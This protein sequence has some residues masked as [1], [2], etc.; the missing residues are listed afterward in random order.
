[1]T[2]TACYSEEDA[3]RSFKET[4]TGITS[5]IRALNPSVCARA[6]VR[7]RCVNTL[8]PNRHWPALRCLLVSLGP[9]LTGEKTEA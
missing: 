9:C 6:C 4:Y 1:M 7:D 5:P 2:C 3:L 8:P